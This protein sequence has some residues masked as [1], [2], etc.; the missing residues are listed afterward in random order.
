VAGAA[1][2]GMA[3]IDGAGLPEGAGGAAGTG[4]EP[5]PLPEFDPQAASKWAATKVLNRNFIRRLIM[6]FS[7]SNRRSRIRY[8]EE[9][10]KEG[11]KSKGHLRFKKEVC[12]MFFCKKNRTALIIGGRLALKKEILSARLF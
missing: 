6:S 12:R 2:A 8:R 3:P 9:V 7:L 5:P 4:E 11:A 1:G 10:S